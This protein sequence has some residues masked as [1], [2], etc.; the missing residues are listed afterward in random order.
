MKR[1][2]AEG[3]GEEDSSVAE[4]NGLTAGGNESKVVENELGMDRN[5]SKVER[6][7]QIVVENQLEDQVEVTAGDMAKGRILLT[8]RGSIEIFV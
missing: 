3:E 2:G 4:W 8:D 6:I 7:N 5:S 1:N